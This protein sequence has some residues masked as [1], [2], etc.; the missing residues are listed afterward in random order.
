M[1]EEDP[2]VLYVSLHRLD[3]FPAKPE[4]AD[5]NVIGAGRGA[6]YTVN[7][8]WPRRGMGDS[9]Y[10]A[11]FQ[12]VVMPIAYQFNPQLVLVAAGFD[13]AQGDPL[14]GTCVT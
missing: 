4:E 11:A 1:F 13:A 14:G 9:E 8:A 5:C 3:L 2:R 7:I 6:G 10:L 12:Q